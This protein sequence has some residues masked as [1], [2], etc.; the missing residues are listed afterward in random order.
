VAF[1][2]GIEIT[3]VN[4]PELQIWYHKKKTMIQMTMQNQKK[5]EISSSLD[6]A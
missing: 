4:Q 5:K 3:N 6:A 2:Q 1:Q